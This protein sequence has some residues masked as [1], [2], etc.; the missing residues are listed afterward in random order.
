MHLP[1]LQLL[2]AY[3]W[4]AKEIF[5]FFQPLHGYVP[6]LRRMCSIFFGYV[7]G[8]IRKLQASTSVVAA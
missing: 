8:C 6:S 3:L 4:P 5:R 7:M 2:A 1:R